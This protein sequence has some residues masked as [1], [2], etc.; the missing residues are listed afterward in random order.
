MVTRLSRVEDRP[1][2][3]ALKPWGPNGDR[4][5]RHCSLYLGLSL[6]GKRRMI[7]D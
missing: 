4:A 7:L 1:E 5:R 3:S 6:N 2:E